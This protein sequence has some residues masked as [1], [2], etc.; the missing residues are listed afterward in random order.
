MEFGQ[1]TPGLGLRAG[2]KNTAPGRCPSPGGL[3]GSHRCG[4]RKALSIMLTAVDPRN[5]ALAVHAVARRFDAIASL[6]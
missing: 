4:A 3:C 2:A 5:T 6:N 1:T